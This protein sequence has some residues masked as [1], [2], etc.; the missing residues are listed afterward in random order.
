M[1]FDEG[2]IILDKDSGVYN[3]GDV[4][5]GKIVFDQGRPQHVNGK[6]SIIII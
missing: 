4:I 2:R 1:S 6:H 5:H 3:V